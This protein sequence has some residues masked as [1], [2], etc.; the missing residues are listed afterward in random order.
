V[1]IHLSD[2]DTRQAMVWDQ[3]C[4]WM[5]RRFVAV[6]R[7]KWYRG[8]MPKKKMKVVVGLSPDDYLSSDS[9]L[10]AVLEK[11]RL[12]DRNDLSTASFRK[13]ED[14]FGA[15]WYFFEI[16]IDCPEVEQ[17]PKSE[18]TRPGRKFFSDP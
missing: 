6:E 5:K 2:S 9:P 1:A 16:E 18:L 10:A 17:T 14:P 11:L 15:D 3:L 13:I 12:S 4:N 8:P 7:K